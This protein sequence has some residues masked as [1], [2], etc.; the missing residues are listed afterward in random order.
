MVVL[1]IRQA[2]PMGFV[3]IVVVKILCLGSGTVNVSDDEA[4]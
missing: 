1:K 4:S 2:A 3:R